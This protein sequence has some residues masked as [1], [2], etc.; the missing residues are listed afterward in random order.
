MG[1][2]LINRGAGGKG[3]LWAAQALFESPGTVRDIHEDY[4]R[5]G[6]DIITTNSY[7]TIRDKF[8][9]AGV[10]DRF[11]EMNQLAGA[12]ILGK[13]NTSEFGHS[14][15][16]ENLLGDHCRNPWDIDR[17][18]G[19]SSGGAGAGLAAGLHP[20]AQG[21]DGGGSIRIPSS[22]CGVF[23][24]KPT[25]GRVPRPYKG[26]GGWGQFSQNGPMARTVRDVAMLLQV[27]AGPDPDDPIALKET[28]PEFSA[29]LNNGVK[30][31]RLGWTPD[32]GS[33]P[34]DPE[35]KRITRESVR[36]FE[37]MGATV[38]EAEMEIDHDEVRDLFMT[39]WLSDYIA[40]YGDLMATRRSELT[41]LLAEMLEEEYGDGYRNMN[42]SI[43]CE[44]E[45]LGTAGAL[46]L[47]V[48]LIESDSALILNGDSYCTL[49][50][51]G[52]YESHIQSGAKVSLALIHRDDC[53]AYGRVQLENHD[54]VVRFEE[55]KDDEM[56]QDSLGLL[57]LSTGLVTRIGHVKSFKLP[58]DADGFL[59]YHLEKISAEPDSAKADKKTAE[60]KE[61]KD[62][63]KDKKKKQEGTAL[64][65]RNLATDAET[66]FEHATDYLF[67]E[68]GSRLVYTAS[69]K[70]G[71]ADAIVAVST[72]QNIRAIEAKSCIA[73][74]T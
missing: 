59:A 11:R 28:P 61:G 4:I 29:A 68:D 46:R 62:K 44:D 15:T 20:L 53:R 13:T 16:T 69:N 43:S 48:L 49:D 27:M 10:M 30:G 35:V 31:L 12:I 3:V 2:E 50:L 71:S 51:R 42:V 17:T 54:N 5:A 6:A 66:R 32:L 57:D 38:E 60:Q 67:S 24:I 36:A 37:E 41:P 56:P 55:K 21:S 18:S 73:A 70:D 33:L 74:P 72:Y 7:S 47:A 14:A 45:P 34:V 65:L 40:S 23:G 58:E 26:P 52:Y 63:K 19:G 9:A 8:E 64:V 25:Q 39:I 1:Q 22:L